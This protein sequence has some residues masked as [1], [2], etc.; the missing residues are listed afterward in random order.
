MRGISGSIDPQLHLPDGDD[1]EEPALEQQAAAL[2]TIAE[3]DPNANVDAMA[4]GIEF[5]EVRH[6]SLGCE[7]AVH[8]HLSL[9]LLPPSISVR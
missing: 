6:C 2:D 9:Q 1:G 3:R 4:A 7:L 5:D 8:V